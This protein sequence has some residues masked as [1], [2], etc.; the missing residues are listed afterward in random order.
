[1]S[2]ELDRILGTHGEGAG[3]DERRGLDPAGLVH[4]HFDQLLTLIH[5]E[6]PPFGQAAGDPE[7]V[8]VEVAQAV[9]DN[10]A[11]GVKVDVVTMLAT[12]GRDQR[13]R[14]SA[15]VPLGPFACFVRSC[16]IECLLS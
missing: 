11:V 13:V 1:M 12:E 7:A 9:T 3:L 15:E 5:G 6:S 10:G 16:H 8:V 4:R 2:G 14:Y